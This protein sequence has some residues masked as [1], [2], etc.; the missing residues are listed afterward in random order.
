MTDDGTMFGDLPTQFSPL[1]V[2]HG[3]LDPVWTRHKAQLIAKYIYLFTII[4]RHGAYIDGFAGPKKKDLKNSWAAELVVETHPR[5]L[6][7]VFLCDLN[8]KGVSALNDLVNR[9]T[10]KNERQ[11]S[12]Y[13]GDFN[14]RVDDILAS[15]L[16]K[17]KTATFCL[18]DQFTLECHWSTL[19][20]LAK[21]KTDGARKI[22]LFY[23]LATGWLHRTLAGHTVNMNRPKLWWGDDSWRDLVSENGEKIAIRMAERFR[24]ELNYRYVRAYPVFAKQRGAGRVMFHMIHASDH[25]EAHNLMKRAHRNVVQ[26]AE[27]EEQLEMALSEI[28]P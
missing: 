27:T 9:Q 11:Y 16:I 3:G 22:E 2:L 23:F 19:V 4:T 8:L 7:E 14:Q 13:S 24:D 21:H 12:V 6:R 5:R 28:A 1:S 10:D 25:P 20:K 18:L 17:E 26:P 15:G